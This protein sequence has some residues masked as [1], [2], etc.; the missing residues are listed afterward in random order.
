MFTWRDYYAEYERRLN[1]IDE[2]RHFRL[3]KVF[4]RME[5]TRL[6]NSLVRFQPTQFAYIKE[7]SYESK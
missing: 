7:I 6:R 1:Q 2:A 4:F 5:E 3:I